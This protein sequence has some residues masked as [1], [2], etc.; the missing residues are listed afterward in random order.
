MSANKTDIW[1]DADNYDIMD[2][3]APLLNGNDL[4]KGTVPDTPENRTDAALACIVS[5]YRQLGDL[6]AKVR[7]LESKLEQQLK[8]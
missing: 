6:R 2:T 8:M 5:L 1:I 4:K 3:M 7:V